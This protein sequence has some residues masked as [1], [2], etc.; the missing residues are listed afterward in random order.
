MRK[1]FIGLKPFNNKIYYQ[2]NIFNS[3]SVAASPYLIVAR[4]VLAAKNIMMNTIDIP[5][6]FPTEKDVYFDVPYPWELKHWV[7]IIKNRKKNILFIVEPPIV[8]PFNYMKILHSLFVKVYTW[9][10]DFIDNK[11]YY[12][13]NI[14]KT[15]VGIKTQKVP[16]KRKKL[17]ILMN[18]NWVTFLPFR[19]LSFPTKELYSERV[20][21]LFFFDTRYPS[22]F[23]LYGRGWN[24]PAW[25]SISQRLFGYKKY[26]TYKGGFRSQD[27]YKILSNF[28]FALC[29]ENCEISGYISE[30]IIDC[31]KARCVPVYLGA[32]NIA[33]FISR[34][35]FI[36]FRRFKNYN[37][38]GSFL[39]TTD[40]KTYDSYIGEIEK[41]LVSREY[42]D[43]WTTN[44]FVKLF[45][46]NIT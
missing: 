24:E 5:T 31:F 6:E 14:P 7:R 35:C 2:N 8:N 21:A 42:T 9:N 16:F 26:S 39:E 30:K 33:D 45:E 3:G 15:N 11:K 20:R 27:K 28:K 12:K 34:K 13:F 46:R 36:D 4:K 44:A 32:P 22:D 10:D 29:F 17:A 43:R 23:S 1:R 25:F 41:F 19:L 18:A 40:E 38:L 37:Q